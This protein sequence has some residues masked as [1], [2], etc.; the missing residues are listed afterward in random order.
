[1]ARRDPLL[2]LRS[3][4]LGSVLLALGLVA[5]VDIGHA[6]ADG[7]LSWFAGEHVVCVYNGYLDLAD[8]PE[9]TEGQVY[10]VDTVLPRKNG[11]FGLIVAHVE[12]RA[13]FRAFD[14]R[15][16]MPLVSAE[17]MPP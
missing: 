9:L 3:D 17:A 13:K 15:R 16:F 4:R 5:S 7:V 12:A 1:M 14:E 8:A 2:T 10:T 6:R 11:H